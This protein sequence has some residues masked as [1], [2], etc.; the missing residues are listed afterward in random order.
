MGVGE[1]LGALVDQY[2]EHDT[3]QGG[4]KHLPVMHVQE[5]DQSEPDDGDHR[6]GVEPTV[7]RCHC[8]L[9]P[10]EFLDLVRPDYRAEDADG[11]HHEGEHDPFDAVRWIDRH[12]RQP[13]NQA[14]D[15]GHLVGLEDVRGHARAVPNVIPHQVGD[16]RCVPG[17]VFLQPCFHL[18]C[19]VGTHVGGLGVNPASDPH[20]EGQQSAAKPK[21]QQS[22]WCGLSE[23][24]E[25]RR[26]AEQAQTVG[27]HPGDGAG[28]VGDLQGFTKTFLLR[29]RRHPDV[30]FQRHVHAD[31]A[32]RSGERGTEQ[33]RSSPA[34]GYRQLA[35]AFLASLRADVGDQHAEG[36]QDHQQDDEP[37]DRLQLLAKVRVAAGLDIH[38]DRLH[39]RRA[40]VRGKGLPGK[41]VG[42]QKPSKRH[43]EDEPQSD[44]FEP[45]ESVHTTSSL[46]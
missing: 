28:S 34:D 11:A 32:H 33:E 36:Q 19:K 25:N 23:D 7:D 21:A 37:G 9:V 17:V 22:V 31:V 30:A 6:R 35:E 3:G 24:H 29:S 18:A 44:D 45:S 40:L 15:D 8:V 41:V 20:E 38:P 42:V 13:Q 2:G 43:A 26:P 16:N 1:V 4:R 46:Q 27:Q 12:D 14:R 5:R 39:L 10:A